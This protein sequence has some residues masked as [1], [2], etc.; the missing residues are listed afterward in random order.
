M[1][2]A[3]SAPISEQVRAAC[4]WVAGR[5]G[6][7]HVE[8]AAVA[9]YAEALVAVPAP[10]EDAATQLPGADRET[11]AAFAIC[12]DAINFGSGWWPTIRKRPGHSG[13]AT[14]A[15]GLTERF[16]ER[17]AWAAAELAA[18]SAADVAPVLG[19][20]AGHP[21]MEQFAASLRDV[22][23]HVGTEHGGR[24]E[25]VVESADGSAL[26]LAD[27]L[28]GWD[29]FADVSAYE[30]RPIPFFKRAQLAAA[31][32]DRAGVAKLRDLD[33]LTAF[34]DNL[35]PHVLRLDGVL[36]LDPTLTAKIEAAEL[37]LHGSPEEVELRAGAVHAI[38]LL[39]AASGGR[40][41]PSRIDGLLWNRG[42][43]PRYKALPRPRCRNTAY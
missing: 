15:A 1:T 6:I 30:G 14:I 27:L 11:L 12:L 7:V 42:R 21:L 37:L 38:E 29:A 22:G 4:A 9:E 16:R 19:Q 34:A 28:A 41:S 35:V 18:L 40:L 36:R 3:S 5:A 26:K 43:E 33:R 10:P 24:F 17:G 8:E 23:E 31:D 13:Y 39:A 32:L 20:D 2:A 25:S